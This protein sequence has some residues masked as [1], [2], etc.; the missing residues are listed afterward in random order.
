MGEYCGEGQQQKAVQN[1]GRILRIPITEYCG[2]KLCKGMT[3][4]VHKD[5]RIRWSRMTEHCAER[6]QNI[7]QKDG[8]ILYC[9]EKW[10]NIVEKDG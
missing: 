1:D 7:S 8:R 5:G 2:R 6:R 3:D 10:Q 9:V 4:T